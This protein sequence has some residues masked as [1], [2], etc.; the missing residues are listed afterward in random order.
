MHGLNLYE[1][2]FSIYIW[3]FNFITIIK[4]FIAK[5]FHDF[6]GLAGFY[7]G[8]PWFLEIAFACNFGIGDGPFL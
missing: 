4:L 5:N 8:F 6:Y 2:W 1:I 7:K 3:N